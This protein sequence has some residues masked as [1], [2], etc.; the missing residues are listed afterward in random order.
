M[1]QLPHIN[2]FVI[3]FTKYEHRHMQRGTQTPGNITE[4]N[5]YDSLLL[6]TV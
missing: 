4:E 1:E 6:Q 2:N 3:I 5:S